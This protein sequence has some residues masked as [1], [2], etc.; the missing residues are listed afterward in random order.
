MLEP[1]AARRLPADLLFHRY[2]AGF[3]YLCRGLDLW[4]GGIRAVLF[5][6][7]P[8]EVECFRVELVLPG[9]TSP[10]SARVRR[11]TRQG[12]EDTLE[13]VSMSAADQDRL[14]RFLR[15]AA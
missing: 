7:V 4:D 6:A 2:V 10:L 5:G 13:F 1:R 3:P 15:V 14:A 12:Q 8:D 9:D 11:A